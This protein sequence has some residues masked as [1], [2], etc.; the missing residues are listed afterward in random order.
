[1]NN[2]KSEVLS[3]L[4]YSD[5]FR[6]VDDILEMDE[7]HI[8]GQYKIKE[9][10][11]FFKGHFIGQPMVPGVIISEIMAQIGLVCLGINL[12]LRDHKPPT[13]L[14]VFSNFNIDFLSGAE[15]GDQLIV[16]SSKIYFRLGKLKAKVKCFCNDELIAHGEMSG[17][18]INRSYDE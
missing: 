1:M 18:M 10:E 11:Y 4:P 6:F 12:I 2:L 16:K 7:E 9:D 17:V 13:I 8:V 5:P 15:P 14:P 3:F